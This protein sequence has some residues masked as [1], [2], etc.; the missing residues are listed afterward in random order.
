MNKN[1][2]LP[3]S[4]TSE[5]EANDAF[6]LSPKEEVDQSTHQLIKAIAGPASSEIVAQPRLV[7]KPFS[8]LDGESVNFKI[9]SVEEMLEI[10]KTNKLEN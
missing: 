3:R 6:M 10:H 7:R 8:G 5:G 1:Q 2:I 9:T 4:K